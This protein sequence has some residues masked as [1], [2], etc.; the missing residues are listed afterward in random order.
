MYT[1]SRS[2]SSSTSRNMLVRLHC[3]AQVNCVLPGGGVIVAEYLDGDQPHGRCHAVAVLPQFVEGGVAGLGYVHLDA[4]D[5][6]LQM[7][8]GDVVGS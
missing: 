2:I 5:D 8:S 1:L 7:L 4:V 3:N 6:L